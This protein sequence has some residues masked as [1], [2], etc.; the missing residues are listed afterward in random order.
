[1][2]SAHDRGRREVLQ[3]EHVNGFSSHSEVMAT[4]LL[5]AAVEGE[6]S[7]HLLERHLH[8]NH[9]LQTSVSSPFTT[10]RPLNPWSYNLRGTLNGQFC[11]IIT[12]VSYSRVHSNI[13][14]W[15]P[16]LRIIYPYHDADSLP[17]QTSRWYPKTRNRLQGRRNASAG[18]PRPPGSAI[19]GI[20]RR[21][22]PESHENAGNLLTNPCQCVAPL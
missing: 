14:R 10:R 7:K 4:Y 3:R 22:G 11:P 13:T 8:L 15:M 2:P 17:I 6:G 21:R 18:L 20:C 5:L 19:G 9:A 12:L 1:M 16:T